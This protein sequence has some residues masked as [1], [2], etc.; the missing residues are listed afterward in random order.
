MSVRERWAALE[1]LEEMQTGGDKEV[2]KIPADSPPP[3]RLPPGVHGTARI[4]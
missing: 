3:P 1:I 4:R 2:R